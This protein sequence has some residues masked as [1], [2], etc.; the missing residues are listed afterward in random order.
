MTAVVILN[1][2]GKKFLETFLPGVI[3]FSQ[4]AQIVVADNASTDDSV[5]FVKKNFPSVT[6]IVNPKNEGFAGGYNQALKHVDAKY[7]VLLNSDV[8]VTE[9]WLVPMTQLLE[10][11]ENIAAVQPKILSYHQPEMFEYAGAGGGFI[12]KYGYPFCRGRIFNKL[13]KDEHQYDDTI[14]VFWATGACMMV[15]SDVF[16]KLGGFDPVFF[17]HMEEIDLCWRMQ[18]EYYQVY[19]CGKSTVYHVGGGT[20]S[21]ESPYKTF[22]NFRNNLLMLFKNAPKKQRFSLFQIRFILDFLASLKFL[23]AGSFGNFKSVWKARSEF[24][25]LK[26]QY[27]SDVPNDDIPVNGTGI[28]IYPKSLLW[29]YYLCNKQKFSDLHWTTHSEPK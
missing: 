14:P 26:R 29:D 8:R 11:N 12:D 1:W 24:N 7:F 16:R 20:L 9:N 5:D 21:T 25:R 13:E 28:L 3:K 4:G 2:N 23:L 27:P 6:L 19:Y 22:L 15:R 17:A 10:S 18:R